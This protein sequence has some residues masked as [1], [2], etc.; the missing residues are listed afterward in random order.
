MKR[1]VYARYIH[2]SAVDELRSV[3]DSETYY[4]ILGCMH[5]ANSQGWTYD[6]VKY[7]TKAHTMS[8]IEAWDW[9]TRYEPIIGRSYVFDLSD[10]LSPVYRS[11][12]KGGTTVYHRKHEFVAPDYTGF[13][14]QQSIERTETLEAIPEIH[15][16]KNRI[17]SLRLWTQL[18]AKYNLPTYMDEE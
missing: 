13:D 3:T 2:V 18:L 5:Y 4:A 9:D 6:I 11:S 17:G 12:T 7:D 14:I 10:P 1:V 15:N 8:L 16:N